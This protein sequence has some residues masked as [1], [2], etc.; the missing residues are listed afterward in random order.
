MEYFRNKV[1][2]RNDGLNLNLK[3]FEY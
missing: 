2:L 3:M 1:G